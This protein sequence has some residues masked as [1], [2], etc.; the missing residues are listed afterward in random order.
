MRRQRTENGSLT[1]MA[2]EL[3]K[4]LP[5]D[6]IPKGSVIL[7]GSAA[8]MGIVNAERYAAEWAKN[9]NW[10]QERLGEIIILPG[11]PLTSSGIVDRCVLRNLLDLSAW[12]NSMPD[13]ELRLLRN[14]R[15]C[16]EDTYLG[17]IRRGPG[18]ADYRLNMVMPVSLSM[19]A[20]TIP[21]TSGDWG[22]R[23]TVLVALNEAGERYWIEKIAQELNREIGL[24]LATAWSVGWTM[25]AVRRQEEVVAVGRV[26][27]IGASNAGH[28]A[29]ALER[30]GIK[31]VPITTPGCTVTREGVDGILRHLTSELKKDDIVLVQWF[32]NSI[33]FMLNTKT[34]SMELPS[35]NEQDGIFHVTGKVTVSKD[36]Q[37]EA[38][39]D[40]LEPLLAENPENLK[41]LLCPLVRYLEDCCAD[42]P[43]DENLK[44]EDGVRQ[45]KELYQFRR[46]L[47]SWIIRKKFRN[48]I[49]LDP[50]GCLG[51]AALL[52]KAKSVMADCFHLNSRARETVAGE[53]KEQI[54]EWLRGKKRGSDTPVGGDSKRLKLDAASGSGKPG[55]A[56]GAGA[57]RAAGAGPSRAAAAGLSRK[58]DGG[59][60]AKIG[61]KGRK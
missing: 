4:L 48:T 42:H 26:F 2:D 39:L 36:L 15:K 27:S 41:V 5:K 35:R 14:A 51:A 47:K 61:G 59:N 12:Y 56:T 58:G 54:V 31:V 25:S 11:I 44:R 3:L 30:K 50:L 38:L 37:L 19:D 40:K 49:M 13:P 1:E 52:D 20:G 32:E 45:L 7:Y 18:W 23:P 57:G 21:S 34:G 22:E 33:F 55:A 60:R 8:Y 46:V 10:M 17:K 28:T 16:W 24:G 29:A 9:R 6:G 53:I 43:R